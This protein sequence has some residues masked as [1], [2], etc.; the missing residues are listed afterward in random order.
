MMKNGK[1]EDAVDEF[2]KLKSPYA[3]Y[4]Q[5]LV[6]TRITLYP[7]QILRIAVVVSLDLDYYYLEI[8]FELSKMWL[9]WCL[10]CVEGSCPSILKLSLELFIVP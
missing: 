7:Q 1:Y 9:I 3:T 4:Y 6:S 8:I 5:A 10:V 2:Q